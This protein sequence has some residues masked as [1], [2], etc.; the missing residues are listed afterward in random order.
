VFHYGICRIHIGTKSRH[1]TANFA[2]RRLQNFHFSLKRKLI[3]FGEAIALCL[4]VKTKAQAQGKSIASAL[5]STPYNFP[6]HVP[7]I[8]L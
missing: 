7:S 8:I 1:G 4:S 2:R 3:D 5:F 6:L